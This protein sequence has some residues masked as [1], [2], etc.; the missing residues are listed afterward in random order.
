MIN[1]YFRLLYYLNVFC[2]HAPSGTA[3]LYSI[4][5][6]NDWFQKMVHLG[7]NL[8]LVIF[9]KLLSFSHKADMES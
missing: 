8:E 3:H 6:F 4:A 1:D 5:D 9:S 7:G 2:Q